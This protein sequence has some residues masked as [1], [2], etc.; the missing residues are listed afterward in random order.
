MKEYGT[1]PLYNKEYDTPLEIVPL[2]N[3]NI[4]ELVF[5]FQ[6]LHYQKLN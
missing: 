3:N 6:L 1:L 2:Y 5:F 4:T